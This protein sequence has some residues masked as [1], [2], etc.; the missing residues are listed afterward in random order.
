[1]LNHLKLC[2]FIFL[3]ALLFNL[4]IN[5]SNIKREIF[6]R[7]SFRQSQTALTVQWI[8]N[9]SFPFSLAYKTPIL[10]APW[11]IPFE[12][13]LYQYAVSYLHIF[14][15]ENILVS[16]RII[17]LSLFYF[18]VLLLYLMLVKTTESKLLAYLASTFFL[19]D[20]I[21]LFWGGTIMI[22]STALFFTFLFVYTYLFSWGKFGIIYLIS[23]TFGV[24]A[25]IIKI[26][27]I[28]PVFIILCF[29]LAVRIYLVEGLN[30]SSKSIHKILGTFIMVIT[31]IFV[32]KYWVGLSDTYKKINEYSYSITGSTV[33]NSWNFGTL[34]QRLN[35][36]NW[37]KVFYNYGIISNLIQG[38]IF[39]TFFS[40]IVYKLLKIKN[41]YKEIRVFFLLV[42][43]M[44][45]Y[46]LV[47]FNLYFVH[48][49][50][51]YASKFIVIILLAA[52]A[53]VLY[54]RINK[55]LSVIFII[56]VLLN[57][58][59]SY[60]NLYYKHIVEQKEASETIQATD[61][62]KSVSKKE[63]ILFI[64]GNDWGSEVA[65]YGER[66][67]IAITNRIN[68]INDTYFK[69]LIDN[70]RNLRL[71]YLVV[72]KNGSIK[73]SFLNEFLIYFG[74][75]L[76]YKNSVYDIYYLNTKV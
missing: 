49:Y 1:M 63:D 12:F 28:L 30:L 36:L 50:Y 57:S 43:S 47:F 45:L 71:H 34:K 42:F 26:T 38:L 14:T 60:Y 67:S 54:E 16:G 23:L 39:I 69:Y 21:Y 5:L 56:F 17:S 61:F 8:V 55:K 10:G 76:L 51:C 4:A 70:H 73:N 7:H 64:Y 27:T 58:I 48:T 20:P 52:T 33:L 19:V 2:R 37:A 72:K 32:T 6:D 46:P 53:C 66:K 59:F 41:M 11:V 13:P 3:A 44:L 74:A 75:N 25:S 22:E 29:V 65:Y 40:I 18:S 68:S 15:G 35:L 24:L 9:D 31:S 62:I